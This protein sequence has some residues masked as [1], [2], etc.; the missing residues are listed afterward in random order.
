MQMLVMLSHHAQLPEEQ[1][2]II[3]CGR[4]KDELVFF[5]SIYIEMATVPL[6][7]Y[8]FEHVVTDDTMYNVAQLTNNLLTFTKDDCKFIISNTPSP[9]LELLRNKLGSEL[10]LPSMHSPPDDNTNS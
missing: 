2:D 1:F 9:L 8:S 6:L 4:N 7:A 10:C 3:I 5:A